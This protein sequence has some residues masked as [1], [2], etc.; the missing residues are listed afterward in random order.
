VEL[1]IALL[2]VI[3]RTMNDPEMAPQLQH[4]IR[5]GP[6][7]VQAIEN[8]EQLGKQLFPTIDPKFAA[9]AAAST[10]FDPVR[11]RWV[12]T[13]LNVLGAKPTLDIDGEYGAL[14]IEAVRRFQTSN[15]LEVDGWAGDLTHA[16]LQAAVTEANKIAA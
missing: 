3:L 8:L 16:A 1:L 10:I 4:A 14:T 5:N 11:V 9:A 6:P 13:A 7:T 12:Q 15:G 2:P